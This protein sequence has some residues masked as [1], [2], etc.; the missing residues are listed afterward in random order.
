MHSGS[1]YIKQKL[2][3][4]RDY[5]TVLTILQYYILSEII[6]TVKTFVSSEMPLDATFNNRDEKTVTITISGY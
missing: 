1:Q 2:Q 4:F 5:V 6:K 3:E